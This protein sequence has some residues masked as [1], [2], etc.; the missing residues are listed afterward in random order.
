MLAGFILVRILLDTLQIW[1]DFLD[2]KKLRSKMN[3]SRQTPKRR[4]SAKLS[5][6]ISTNNNNKNG[7]IA[8]AT[9]EMFDSANIKRLFGHFPTFSPTPGWHK[10]HHSFHLNKQAKKCPTHD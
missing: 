10:V 9:A 2:L 3:I 4:P 5:Q 1:I 8:F 7:I 6:N